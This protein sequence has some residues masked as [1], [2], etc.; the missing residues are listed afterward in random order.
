LRALCSGHANVSASPCLTRRSA[1]TQLVQ[2]MPPRRSSRLQAAAA[3]A[4]DP[5]AALPHALSLALFALLPVDQR[6]RCAEVCR[7]WRALLS[8]VSLWLRLDLSAASGVAR[9]A[10]SVP[11]MRAAAARAAG[12]LQALDLTDCRRNTPEAVCVVAAQNAG[13]LAE[14]RVCGLPTALQPGFLC[15]A[16]LEQLLRAAPQLRVLEAA[17]IC[18][19]AEEARRLLRNEAP[20]GPLRVRTLRL[21]GLGDAD[22]VR[23]LTQ[24]L[25]SHTW[26]TGLQL[27]GAPLRMPAALDA[28]VD[29]ALLLRL[30]NLEFFQCGLTPASAPSLARVLGG[31]ALR[32]L[33]ITG[34]PSILLNQPAALLLAEALRANT[35]L[36]AA[37]F[38]SI[39]LFREP[40]IAAAMLGALTAHPSLRKLDVSGNGT[41]GLAAPVV[42]AAGAALAAL[43]AA[44]APALQELH[45]CYSRLGDA[46]LGALVDA[47]PHNTHLRMLDC[48]I[49]ATSEAFMRDRLL[50]AVRANAWLEATL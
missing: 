11:L 3:P 28:V 2:A 33:S 40:A 41:Y 14:L 39:D 45:M 9:N 35:T 13:A 37:T 24:E 32:T 15:P 17:A 42:A 47:L 20:F 46:G 1:S 7:S 22:A 6:L 26:L 25:P 44:N 19:G 8:D 50:P 43:V 48:R 36:T 38:K 30:T 23:S 4:C 31:S 12:G 34:N 5:F 27:V 29:T 49:N 10:A 18:D 16:E 21:A